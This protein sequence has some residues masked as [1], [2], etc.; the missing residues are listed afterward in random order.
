MHKMPQNILNQLEKCSLFSA[1]LEFK[2][3]DSCNKKYFDKVRDDINNKSDYKVKNW[4]TISQENL[5]ILE[6]VK[7]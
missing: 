2:I 5:Y 7:K 3:G 4:Y 6:I 1:V